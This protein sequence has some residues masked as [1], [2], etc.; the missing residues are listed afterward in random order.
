MIEMQKNE[1]ENVKLVWTVAL[2]WWKDVIKAI[3]YAI[4]MNS[5]L[6]EYI[7]VNKSSRRWETK[8]RK[9][10]TRE[11]L[12]VERLVLI[13]KERM[14]RKVIREK[15]WGM[16]I[17]ANRAGDKHISIQTPARPDLHSSATAA[18]IWISYWYER[19][20]E[21]NK[22]LFPLRRWRILMS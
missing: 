3:N 16:Q 18:S 15:Q 5:W 9:A 19:W 4:E 8:K 21:L 17:S 12:R 14:K 20:I 10:S 11:T 13:V 22:L 7:I 6:N 1:Q 2:E